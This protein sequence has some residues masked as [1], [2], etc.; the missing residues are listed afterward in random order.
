MQS[1]ALIYAIFHL[2]LAFS[3]IPENRR[4][5]VISQCYWPLLKLVRDDGIPLGL[6][7]TAFT[8]EEIERLDPDW[9]QLLRQLL[10]EDRCELIASGDT[11]LIGPLVPAR[12]NRW[13]IDLGTEAYQRILGYLPKL[14]Y[15]NEQAVSASLLDLYEQAGYAGIV[16]EWDNPRM[17]HPEWGE[18]P[19]QHPVLARTATGKTLPVLWNWSIAFQKFQRF[20]HGDLTMDDY[21][22]FF[23][24][25]ERSGIRALSIYGNDAEIFDFRPG[26]YRDELAISGKEWQRIGCLL[27]RLGES[28]RWGLPRKVL[29]QQ[30]NPDCTLEL[31]TPEYPVVVKKQRKYNLTRWAVTGR[32]DLLLNTLCFQQLKRLEAAGNAPSQAERRELCRNWASDYRTHLDESRFEALMQTLPSYQPTC[33]SHPRPLRDVQKIVEIEGWETSWDSERSFLC[34][35]NER[36]MLT[37]NMRRGGAVTDVA[38][39]EPESQAGTLEHGSFRNIELGA[40]FYSCHTVI[41]LPVQRRRVTDLDPAR[42]SM[43]PSDT[44]A[45]GVCVDCEVDSYLGRIRKTYTICS[46]GTVRC[47]WRFPGWSRPEGSLRVGWVTL[48]NQDAAA[49]ISL[50]THHGGEAPE[51]GTI[52]KDVDHGKSVSS[53]VSATSALGGSEGQLFLASGSAGLKIEWFPDQC[54][55]IPMLFNR[56]VG[57]ERLTRVFFSL[58]EIDDTLKKG[59]TLLPFTLAISPWRPGVGA[60]GPYRD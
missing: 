11:Q 44:S 43:E 39:S 35:R 21:L 33:N 2:N 32:D 22:G 20:A 54:A 10:T 49:R 59:G 41:E 55:A 31:T 45:G 27:A 1:D 53:L 19:L 37:L 6:E 46:D 13:N 29:A 47:T 58:V 40:D 4:P 12:V 38:F 24:S 7:I 57:Q 15:I 9:V 3:S 28:Y 26:R 8:L 5:Q 60:G 42:W 14:A 17:L 56:I 16:M 50:A 48:K 52:T 23:A 36:V 25:E 51:V 34:I 30:L 18:T